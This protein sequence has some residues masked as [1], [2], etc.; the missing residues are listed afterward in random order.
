MSR[1]P[2]PET[3][4]G[5]TPP[6]FDAP[7]TATLLDMLLELAREQWVTKNRLATLEHWAAHEV[8]GA[9]VPWSE[10][11][12]LPPEAAAALAAQ[13]DAFVRRVMAPVEAV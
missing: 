5:G 7:E 6:I 9:R 10:D 8:T 3:A 4:R 2:L 12:R 11:Y 13:R 1:E